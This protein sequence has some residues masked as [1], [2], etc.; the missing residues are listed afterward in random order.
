MWINGDT[1]QSDVNSSANALSNLYKLAG[2]PLFGMVELDKIER[3]E[4]AELSDLLD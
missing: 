2:N 1:K 4:V 3:S